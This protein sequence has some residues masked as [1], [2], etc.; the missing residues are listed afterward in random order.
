VGV[1]RRR[2]RLGGC[3][4]AAAAVAV[5]GLATAA[6][7]S[8]AYT[9]QAVAGGAALLAKRRPIER[10][11]A[12]GALADA[13]RVRLAQIPALRDFARDALALPVGDAYTSFVSLGREAVTWNVVATPELSLAPE[14]WCFPVAGCVSYR[15]YFRERGARRF[16]AKLAA[17]G[18]D[19]TV[20]EAIAY[21]S[22]GWFDDPVLDTF[23]ALPEWDLA[24]LVFHELAHRVAYA[25]DDTAFNE[26]YATAVEELGVERWLA[27]R[28]DER[29]AAAARGALAEERRFAA[30]RGAAR[31][32][33]A[34]LYASPADDAA[35]RA[36]K[37]RILTEFRAELRRL[38]DA[39]ELGPRW[40]GWL[41][42]RPNNADFAAAAEYA[43]WV[44]AL[45][46]LFAESS[47]F[48]DFHAA[49]RELAALPA[50]ERAT[51]LAAL[52]ARARAATPG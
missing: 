15:G 33:L 14:T 31:E 12:R 3:P 29:L 48:A 36:G 38:R 5:A 2:R 32:A 23:L 26:S 44:P 46:R 22:L 51:R 45:R 18:L 21:S 47:G 9:T 37:R 42:R 17:R 40:D 1:A 25:G 19:V 52:D 4:A 34:A 7:S 43:R 8:L 27:A 39:G 35:K 41:A 6:C 20:T 50:G 16:A 10:V 13:E 24:G 30:L 49:A 11:L 28:G